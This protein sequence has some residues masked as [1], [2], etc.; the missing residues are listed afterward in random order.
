[1]LD[2][3][4]KKA[5]KI[6]LGILLLITI[7]VASFFIFQDYKIEQ[8]DAYCRDVICGKGGFN[9]TDY[10]YTS[11]FNGCFCLDGTWTVYAEKLYWF[12]R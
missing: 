6:T 5:L 3:S 4:M 2:K 7:V 11:K 8:A 9:Y 10:V 12:E 1:M